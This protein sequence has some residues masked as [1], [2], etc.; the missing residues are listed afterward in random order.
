MTRGER[1]DEGLM[2]LTAERFIEDLERLGASP[3]MGDIF[4]LAREYRV[5]EP[6]EIARLIRHPAH[7]VRVGAVS[8]MDFQARKTKTSPDRRRELYELYLDNHEHIDSWGLVDRAAPY[9]VGGY[10]WDKP[11][12]PLY[13]LARSPHPMERRTAIVATYY[14]IRQ[15]D[16]DDTFRIGGILAHDPDELVQKAVGGWVREAGKQDLDMLRRYLDAYAPTMPRVALRYAVEHLDPAE[17]SRYL[18]LRA[19]T[20]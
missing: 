3:R 19:A 6:A 18:G 14:F 10:L 1:M 5:M 12:D 4:A 17:R 15:H 20:T 2:E 7:D 11:R 13:E 8:V 9:V 16:L